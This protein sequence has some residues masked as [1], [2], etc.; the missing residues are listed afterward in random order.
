[1]S[2]T[3]DEERVAGQFERFGT[4]GLEAKG[5]PDAS[6]GA[7]TQA[8]S[9][10]HG[11]GA[12]VRRVARRRFERQRH[13]PFDLRVGDRPWGARPWL[14][15]QP[16]RALDH[17][18]LP[19]LADGVFVQTQFARDDAV[20]L[21]R[22]TLQHY[23]GALCERLRRGPTTRPAQQRLAL[24]VTERQRWKRTTWGHARPPLY[25]RTRR[26]CKSFR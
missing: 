26:A 2:R 20:R 22:R 10:G 4:M 6:D 23:P 9:R 11:A 1:M 19:P 16:I 15:Q 7:L 18:P 13:D 17:K 25:K 24:G 12:P 5:P 21:V 3:F 14:V 8:T